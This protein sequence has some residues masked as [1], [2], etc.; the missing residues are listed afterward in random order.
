MKLVIDSRVTHYFVGVC[1]MIFLAGCAGQVQHPVDAKQTVTPMHPDNSALKTVPKVIKVDGKQYRIIQTPFGIVKQ[2]VT[3][4]AEDHGMEETTTKKSS[5]LSIQKE[6]P[7]SETTQSVQTKKSS[8]LSVQKEKPPSKTTKTFDKTS[9]P[10]LEP[11]KPAEKQSE[12]GTIVLNFDDADLHEVIRTIADLLKINYIVDPGVRGNVTIHTAGAIKKSDLFP[13]FFQILEVNGLTAVKEG[14][15]YR[16]T[17]LKEAS[18]LPILSRYGRKQKDLPPDERVIMQIIPLKFIAASEIVKL[19][20][21]FVSAEGTIISHGPSNTLTIVDKGI[22]IFKILKLVDTFDIDLFEKVKYR[23]Y[24]LNFIDADEM[25]KLLNQI[26]PSYGKSGPADIKVISIQRLNMLLAIS[27]NARFFDEIEKLINKLDVASESTQPQLYVYTVKN[28]KADDLADLLG[29]VFSKDKKGANDK[30]KKGKENKPKVG[31]N[32]FIMKPKAKKAG[33]TRTTGTA[34]EAVATGT[35][36]G[37]IK[38]TKDMIR[39]ALII[40]AIPSDY[41]I[42]KSILKHLDV[43]PRQV[44]I[45]AIIAEVSLD[46]ETELGVEWKYVKG[47]KTMGTSL[48]SAAMGSSGLQY[49]IGQTDRW[50]QALSALATENKVNI[51]SS[52]TVLASDNK[53]AKINISTE[54]PVASST[55]QTT[56]VSDVISTNIQYRST[57]IILTVTP[58]IN[59]TGLVSMEISQEVSEQSSEVQVGGESYPSFFDRSVNTTLTVKDNQTIVIG[60]LIRQSKSK[61]TTGVP[62]LIKIPIIGF[63]FGKSKDTVDKKELIILITPRVITSLEDV[64]A[65]TSDFKKK[66]GVHIKHSTGIE[67]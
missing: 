66:A 10:S 8:A 40:E 12:K 16:V 60:G 9:S 31:S 36:R 56:G 44:L 23:F 5:A 32:P 57:G 4:P 65:V 30:I 18:R 29:Q 47:P 33:E 51:L 62:G 63:L 67:Y 38:I 37:K 14:S 48:L 17:K 28:V 25:V 42:I 27:K 50:T 64:D 15:L 49:V 11:Q 20:A 54:V 2:R 13:V 43:M 7:P 41:R 21:P 52:P 22:N 59:E 39:N 55:Y 61:G 3:Q 35:L 58:H 53:E 1:V 6:K 24:T 34:G 45:E 26:L 19:L 46:E